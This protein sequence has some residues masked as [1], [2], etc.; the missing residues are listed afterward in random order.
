MNNTPDSINAGKGPRKG[1]LGWFDAM[2]RVFRRE[3]SLV[4]G[5]VGVLLFFV[6]LPLAYPVTYT[7]IYNPEIVTEMPV[8]VVDHSRTPSSR[9]LVNTVDASP[10]V[11]IYAQCAN[12]AEAKDL[13]G[14]NE[15]FAVM[16]IPADYEK[17]LMRGEQ[18]T[19]PMYYEMSLLLRYRSFVSA[20]TEVQL[21]LASDITR[22][23]LETMGADALLGPGGSTLP[24]TSH[25]SFLGDYG[26]GFASFI[27]PGVLILILQQSMVL[28]ICMLRGTSNER[29]RR[30][31]GYDPLQVQGAPISA[32]LWGKALC[33]IVCYIPMTIYVVRCV[34][35]MFSLPHTGN[36]LDYLLFLVPLL[37]ATAMFGQVVAN[38]CTER[39]SCFI[40]VVFTSILFL[41]ISGLTWPRYA[42]NKFWL[43]LGDTIPA[44]WGIEGF[45]RINS[46]GASLA[47]TSEPYI[48]LWVMTAV[49]FLLAWGILAWASRPSRKADQ[50]QTQG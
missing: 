16:E 2:G 48:A 47:E 28:G 34:P 42:M 3:F 41:F 14:K 39:E 25:N 35:E 12:L 6:V 18:A 43:W 40:V 29:R 9:K 46:N 21:K 13:F 45:V 36:P 27:M 23:R 31:R 30:N 24:I 37:L 20:M 32:S 50:A 15:V 22:T 26:Q 1:V 11:S 44:T 4:V 8:A 49:Y 7:L 17:K 38:F 10:A 5:D 33:Y 19:V